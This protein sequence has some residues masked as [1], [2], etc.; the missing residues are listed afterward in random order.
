[1][2]SRE[3]TEKRLV[4]ARAIYP[5]V[6]DY[7]QGAILD[8]SMGY[9]QNFSVTDKSDIDYVFVVDKEEL[10]GLMEG[11]YFKDDVPENVQEMFREGKIDYFWVSRYLNDIETNVFVY[12]TESYVDF[13]LLQGGLK[14]FKK[15]K[16]GD[17][18][19][20]Y[21]FDGKLLTFDRNLT[22][23]EGGFLYEKPA[24][25]DGKYW[26]GP[27]RQHLFFSGHVMFEKD[28]FFSELK[29]YAWK[30]A[31]LQLRHEF[32]NDLDRFNILNTHYTYQTFRK[33]LPTEIV[34]KIQNRTR[35]E[36]GDI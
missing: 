15:D 28:N 14:G 19:K 2:D 1:M 12:D 13:C 7:I 30:A 6:E 33:R 36:L 16:P 27:P 8:G 4:I 5:T 29:D 10:G 18:G 20:G 22:P 31:I 26:G 35:L 3:E 34:E 21:G 11:W 24:L 17:K 32:G 25:V 23:V 9:G